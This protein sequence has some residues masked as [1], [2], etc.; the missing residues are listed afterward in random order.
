MYVTYKELQTFY[1]MNDRKKGIKTMMVRNLEKITF[2]TFMVKN[3]K[4]F[5]MQ[6]IK[7]LNDHHVTYDIAMNTERIKKVLSAGS[8]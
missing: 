3:M 6:E 5:L 8:K 1:K 2:N 7:L 4:K